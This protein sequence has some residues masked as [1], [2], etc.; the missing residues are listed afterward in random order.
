MS[1]DNERTGHCLCG[2]VR[3]TATL[4]KPHVGACHCGMCRRW[5]SGIHLSMEATDLVFAEGAPVKA[6]VSSDWGR[7][8]FCAECG[9][10]LAWQMQNGSFS[11]VSP[12]AL[13]PPVAA[14]VRAEFFIDQKPDDYALDGVRRQMT[15][16]ELMAL[17]G[18]TSA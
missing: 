4:K 10:Q 7:R 1:D 8:L 2:A 15:G 3:F 18:R 6:Y 12:Y 11:G 9:T 14:P 13:D 5:A 16:E 17:L